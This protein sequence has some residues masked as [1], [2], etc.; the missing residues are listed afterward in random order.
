MKIIDRFFKNV[1]KR[2]EDEKNRACK[3]KETKDR[4]DARLKEKLSAALESLESVARGALE[5][6]GSFSEF[7]FKNKIKDYYNPEKFRIIIAN[8][9][10]LDIKGDTMTDEK[11]FRIYIVFESREKYVDPKA[12]VDIK[13]LEVS[14][15]S[16]WLCRGI[17][18][19]EK[20]LIPR[21]DLLNFIERI[22]NLAAFVETCTRANV[23]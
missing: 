8:F 2:I 9:K 15:G 20:E 1:L 16:W 3:E 21:T 13:N 18:H 14:C 7:M 5:S 6:A 22:D 23:H 17:R 12:L 10:P 4:E 11:I 19:V